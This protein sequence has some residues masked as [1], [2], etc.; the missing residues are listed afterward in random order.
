MRRDLGFLKVSDYSKPFRMTRGHD[1]E[2]NLTKEEIENV[3]TGPGVY[4][5]VSADNTKFVYPKGNSSVIYIGKADNLR[6]RLREHLKNLKLVIDSEEADMRNHYQPCSRYQYM[7][8]HK[9][10]VY[11]FHCLKSTQDAKNLESQIL[12]KFY[13]K[14][15]SLPVGNGARSFEKE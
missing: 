5:I 14:Y 3:T 8:Y 12:W 7:K 2:L 15:R 13:E 9:A 1:D 10:Y 11:T 4:I 6:R